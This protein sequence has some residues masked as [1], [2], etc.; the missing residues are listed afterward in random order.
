MRALSIRQPWAGLIVDGIKDVENR[1]RP[2]R[3]RGRIYVHASLRPDLGPEVLRLML[4]RHQTQYG[5][6]IGT[7]D[8]I[9]CVRNAN[10]P[11]ALPRMWHWVLADARPLRR[12]IPFM[13]QQRFFDV[14]D[15]DL[16]ISH[17]G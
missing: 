3:V 15:R 12:P 13:G 5:A 4:S 6:I 17:R 11:W 14:P 16:P 2:T 9:D 10:S 7:V 8:I 1:S